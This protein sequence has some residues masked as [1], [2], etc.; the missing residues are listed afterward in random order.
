MEPAE[1]FPRW[2]APHVALPVVSLVTVRSLCLLGNGCTLIDEDKFWRRVR[3]N[4]SFCQCLLQP[5]RFSKLRASSSEIDLKFL[6]TVEF[7][8]DNSGEEGM[9]DVDKRDCFVS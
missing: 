2:S 3:E 5:Y 6:R 7:S 4:L 9:M 1:G 8:L